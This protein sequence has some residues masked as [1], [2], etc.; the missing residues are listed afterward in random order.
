[1]KFSKLAKKSCIPTMVVAALLGFGLMALITQAEE[2]KRVDTVSKYDFNKTIDTLTKTM[3]SKGLMVVATLDHQNMLSMVG[4][5][6][7]GSKTIEFGKPDMGKMVLTMHPEAGLEMPAKVYVFERGDG[8]TV[9]SYYKS[10]YAQ[11][12]PEFS[13]VDEMMG[14][15]LSEIVNEVNK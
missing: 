1:M 7:K 10:H 8:K 11:Y 4:V 13:K 2:P 6:M 9:M 15:M 12:N 5:K 14:M 3:K